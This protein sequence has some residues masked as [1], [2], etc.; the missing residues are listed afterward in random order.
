MGDRAMLP[1]RLNWTDPSSEIGPRHACQ[2][3]TSKL[4]GVREAEDIEEHHLEASEVDHLDIS[5]TVIEVLAD[6]TP[7]AMLRRMLAAEQHRSAFKQIRANFLL[8]PSLCHQL[9][10]SVF[11]F[12]PEDAVLLVSVKEILGRGQEWLMDV[13]RTTKFA[14]EELEV[15]S[16][17]EPGQL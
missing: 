7:V 6:Q 2:A 17:R 9:K 14:E 1:G 12:V 8:D 15:I 3:S 11:V 13:V 5:P 4:L 10:E 16:L